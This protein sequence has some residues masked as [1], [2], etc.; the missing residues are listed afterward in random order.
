MGMSTRVQ[1]LREK[2]DTYEKMESILLLCKELNVKVP[3][4]VYKYFEL[5]NEEY[6]SRGIITSLPIGSVEHY[7]EDTDDVW[8]VDLSLIPKDIT[9]LRFVNSY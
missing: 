1:G 5:I 3:N 2:N 8:E 4:E 9:K 7:T 6:C